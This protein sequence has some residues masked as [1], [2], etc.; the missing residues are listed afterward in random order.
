MRS[1]II[2]IFIAKH[3]LNYRFEDVIESRAFVKLG[4]LRTIFVSCCHE[5]QSPFP[6]NQKYQL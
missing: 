5:F 2:S 3:F 4:G 1:D 6:K